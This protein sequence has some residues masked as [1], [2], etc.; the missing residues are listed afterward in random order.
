MA[1]ESARINNPIRH[2]L[3]G[4]K[5]DLSMSKKPGPVCGGT[6]PAS[7]GSGDGVVVNGARLAWVE[8][9][10]IVGVVKTI[11]AVEGYVGLDRGV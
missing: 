2:T 7:V 9:R 10:V 4:I 5:S 8:I 3:P 6:W 11:V 1:I